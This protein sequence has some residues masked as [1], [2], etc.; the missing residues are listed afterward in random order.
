VRPASFPVSVRAG[1][2]I[3]VDDSGFDFI[4]VEST[5]SQRSFCVMCTSSSMYFFA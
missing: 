5:N 3:D 1:L 2:L 4:V